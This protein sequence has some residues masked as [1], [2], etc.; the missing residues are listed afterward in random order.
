M[1]IFVGF[2]Q[3]TDVE[4]AQLDTVFR[5]EHAQM[6]V[7]WLDRI[8]R[9]ALHD[10][11]LLVDLHDDVVSATNVL[12]GSAARRNV[13]KLNNPAVPARPWRRNRRRLGQ[14]MVGSLL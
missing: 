4:N 2:P 3:E 10:T 7:F 8:A 5:F 12:E 14:L 9:R 13:G 6:H 11:Q 1:V